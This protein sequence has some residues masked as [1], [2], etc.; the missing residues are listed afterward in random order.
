MRHAKA[1]YAAILLAPLC[2]FNAW[3]ADRYELDVTHT[4]IVWQANHFGF[5]SPSGKF[6]K[7]EGVVVLDETKPEKSSVTVTIDT[8]SLRTGIEKFDEHLKSKDFLEVEKYTTAKFVSTKV[9][10]TG[11]NTANVTGDFT[12]HGITK[13][14][15]LEVTLNKIGESPASKKHTAG[16]SATTTIKRSDFGMEYA[17]PGVSDLVNIDIEAEAVLAK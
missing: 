5:S 12:L 3:A 16:F 14:V 9:D 7:S 4:N 17:L 2:A 13:P 8:A 11:K 6:V 10:V 15:V 1:G